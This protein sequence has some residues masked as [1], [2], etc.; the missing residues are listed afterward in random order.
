M[1]AWFSVL[2]VGKNAKLNFQKPKTEHLKPGLDF[3]GHW[4]LGIGHSPLLTTQSHFKD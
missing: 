2:G 3:F 1:K 4:C